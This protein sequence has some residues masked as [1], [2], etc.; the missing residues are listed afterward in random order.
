MG[1]RINALAAMLD[2][3]LRNAEDFTRILRRD[4]QAVGISR[5]NP[6]SGLHAELRGLL[7]LRYTIVG[8]CVEQKGDQI[9]RDLLDGAR[10][11]L[12]SRAPAAHERNMSLRPLFDDF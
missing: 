1:A 8:R 9:A 12:R 11:L 5:V 10:V 4:D 2:I 7:V 3:P 6:A